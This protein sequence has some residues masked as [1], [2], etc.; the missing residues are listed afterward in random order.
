MMKFKNLAAIALTAVALA[1]CDNTTDTLGYSLTA[2]AD[3][4]EILTDSFD[5]TTRS[6]LTDSVLSRSSYSY[7]GR[8]KDTETGTYVKS[9]YSTQFAIL[10]NY[11]LVMPSRDSLV[12]DDSGNLVADSC[13][14]GI[15]FN[16]FD[17]DSLNVMKFTAY[18]LDKPIE[19]GTNYYTNFDPEAEGYLRSDGN[20]LTFSKSYTYEALVRDSLYQLRIPLSNIPYTDKEGNTYNNLGTYLLRKYYNDSTLFKNSYTFAHKVLPGFY[21]KSTG[22]LGNI[23]EVLYTNFRYYFKAVT[24]TDSV[25]TATNMIS[26]TEEVMQTTKIENDKERMAELAADNSCTYLK[27][28]AGIIT[29]VTLPID[30]IK[31]NHE[32]DTISSAK[33]VF[34]CLRN[35]D[36]DGEF[37][38][39]TNVLMIPKDSLYYFFEEKKLPDNKTS[40]LATY[41]STYN[42]YTFNNISSMITQLYQ[43]K[44]SGNVTDDWNKV[45]LIPVSV[46]SSSSSTSSTVTK[47][48]NDMKLKSTR[49]V[50]GSENTHSP[51]K[52]SII[53]NKFIKD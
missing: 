35:S 49:L 52:I 8:I 16:S 13:Y 15:Y 28:P 38:V 42:T 48:S 4:F 31:L 23:G 37:E 46:T 9:H 33:V 19:E 3:Q 12:Y 18:E 27:A 51:I 2:E 30:D 36:D 34:T 21:I 32:N 22:G 45:V 20:Q 29:E 53:Y 26:G 5:V 7:L 24:D 11:N 10:D 40:Y 41:S 47:V 17:G 14:L 43:Y 25:V 1:A 50:G 44:Q 6:L 39:P